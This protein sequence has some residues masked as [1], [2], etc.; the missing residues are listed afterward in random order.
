VRLTFIY[1]VFN[2]LF[3]VVDIM[4]K[5]QRRFPRCGHWGHPQEIHEYCNLCREKHW[6]HSCD[7]R[8]RC[9]ACAHWDPEMFTLVAVV[10]EYASRFKSK[11]PA[12]GSSS[13]A[14]KLDEATQEVLKD[15]G[16]NSGKKSRSRNK[17]GKS[18]KSNVGSH[19]SSK[20]DNLVPKHAKIRE[21]SLS[22]REYYDKEDPVKVVRQIPVSTV[23]VY[24]LHNRNIHPVT[25]MTGV[26]Q[27]QTGCPVRALNETRC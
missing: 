27:T 23:P 26:Q 3:Y 5:V 4:P 22:K 21:K 16:S 17:S 13:P 10:R 2:S 7:D 18:D 8:R 9:D 12:A 11:S 1:L 24:C 6:G 20:S 25:S 19:D 14:Q 15:S